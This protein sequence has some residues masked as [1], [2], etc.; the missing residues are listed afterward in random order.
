MIKSYTIK[1]FYK[2]I[3]HVYNT[4]SIKHALKKIERLNRN[5]KVAKLEMEVVYEHWRKTNF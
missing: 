5:S 3:Y 1:Y 4:A 2:G